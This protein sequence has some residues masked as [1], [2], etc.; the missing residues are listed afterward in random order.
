MK[1]VLLLFIM[2]NIGYCEEK[3]L[4]RLPENHE[5]VISTFSAKKPDLSHATFTVAAID[6]KEINAQERYTLGDEVL[7]SSAPI[8]HVSG[9][10]STLGT[11]STYQ[12][13]IPDSDI[14]LRRI[15]VTVV[16]PGNQNKAVTYRCSDGTNELSVGGAANAPAGTTYTAVGNVNISEGAAVSFSFNTNSAKTPT[17]NQNCEYVVQ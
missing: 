1:G 3:R 14:S 2:V 17:V 5:Q 12:F 13:F 11:G 6:A 15:N 16:I 7:F 9:Y 4:I 10:N 8:M